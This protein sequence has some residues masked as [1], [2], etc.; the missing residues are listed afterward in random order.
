MIIICGKTIAEVERDL[1]MAKAAI[2]TGAPIGVGGATIEDVEQAM[3]GLHTAL[4]EHNAPIDNP[5]CTSPCGCN[6]ENGCSCYEEEEE[7]EDVC[8]ECGATHEE[9]WCGDYCWGCCYDPEDDEEEEEDEEE[10]DEPPIVTALADMLHSLGVDEATIRKLM[11][12]AL[13]M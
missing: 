8:P 1:E 11:Q 12:S 4:G 7:D 3:A 10:E 13:G 5:N 2:A 6:C 9:G